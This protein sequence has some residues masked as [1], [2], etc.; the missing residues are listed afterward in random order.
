VKSDPD[1]FADAL[2][3]GAAADDAG[4]PIFQNSYTSTFSTLMREAVKSAL[5]CPGRGAA[6]S[7]RC[8]A[9]G[10]QRCN[11]GTN[12]SLCSPWALDQQRTTPQVRRAAQHTGHEIASMVIVLRNGRV[13]RIPRARE[14]RCGT[15]VLVIRSGA[16]RER[17]YAGF[18]AMLKLSFK[19]DRP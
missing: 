6:C 17:V 1:V 8:E 3:S 4:A 18:I 14:N 10:T 9:S 2:V 5:S 7:R 11:A 19:F 12:F 15:G 13:N 16:H